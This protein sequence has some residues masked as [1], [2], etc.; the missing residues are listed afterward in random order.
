MD[1]REGQETNCTPLRWVEPVAEAVGGFDL[2]PCASPTSELATT[3]IRESGGLQYD[4]DRHRTVWVNH[5]Y[6]RG[7]PRKWLRKAAT[8][9]GTRTTVCLSKHD[10]SADWFADWVQGH[11]TVLAV[12]N[13]RISFTG[14]SNSAG[15]PNQYAVY[16]ECPPELIDWLQQPTD[17]HT[18]WIVHNP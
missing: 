18:G 10:P 17:E 4:W 12:P 16:G 5:P 3:N 1:L 2:D 15:F 14:Q 8:S 6:G 7:E 9:N 11:A 13:T